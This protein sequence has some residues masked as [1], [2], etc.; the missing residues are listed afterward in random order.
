[1]P[2]ERAGVRVGTTSERGR[3]PRE[4]E[5]QIACLPSLYPAGS[6]VDS[7]NLPESANEV[8]ISLGCRSGAACVE[9]VSPRQSATFRRGR[10]SPEDT[11]PSRQAD[12][13]LQHANTAPRSTR[14]LPLGERH[15]GGCG[16]RSRADCRRC[17]RT[18]IVDPPQRACWRN[19]K[20]AGS[21]PTRKDE[22]AWM[23]VGEVK[24]CGPSDPFPFG[25]AP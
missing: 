15:A 16:G 19:E 7:V 11:G 10:D 23:A 9:G 20:E 24:G 4:Q 3:R 2:H 14:A 21:S 8:T 12:L 6:A 1:M 17:G 13:P 18:R 25:L 22:P 5:H